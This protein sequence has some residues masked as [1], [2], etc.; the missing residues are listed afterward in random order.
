MR[1]VILT[2][3]SW[4][5]CNGKYEDDSPAVQWLGIMRQ[6]GKIENNNLRCFQAVPRDKK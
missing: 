3:P 6:D 1:E 4:L 5:V 2:P